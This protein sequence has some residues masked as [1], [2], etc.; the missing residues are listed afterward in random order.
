MEEDGEEVEEEEAF[1]T[2]PLE[3]LPAKSRV[4]AQLRQT[5]TIAYMQAIFFLHE[6]V[7]EK[8]AKIPISHD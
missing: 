3:S 8:N 7:S 6:A 4:P 5:K 2:V 1:F